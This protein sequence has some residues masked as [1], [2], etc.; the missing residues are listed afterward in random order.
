LEKGFDSDFFRLAFLSKVARE[1]DEEVETDIVD[2]LEIKDPFA[3]KNKPE[4]L[5]LKSWNSCGHS[6]TSWKS[7]RMELYFA[8]I[9]YKSY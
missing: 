2:E 3:A 5:M 6:S 1:S 4:G 7:L 8:L 9:R